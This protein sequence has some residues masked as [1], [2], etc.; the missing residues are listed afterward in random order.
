MK[1]GKV[2]G[3]IVAT[4]KD[5]RLTGHKLLIIREMTPDDD[6]K[7]QT[8]EGNSEVCVV[9]DLVGAGVGEMVIFCT[10]SSARTSTGD[11]RA[12]I[13]GAIVGII[14]TIDVY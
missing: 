6:G 2:I 13:D 9:V 7:P 1:I 8:V 3:N 4:K 12:P 14:D 11:D 5:E 10:G